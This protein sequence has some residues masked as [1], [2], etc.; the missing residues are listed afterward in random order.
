[1][2]G[3]WRNWRPSVCASC[4]RCERHLAVRVRKEA[5]VPRGHGVPTIRSTDR[6]RHVVRSAPF[7]VRWARSA[8]AV[9]CSS[10]GLRLRTIARTTRKRPQKNQKKAHQRCALNH[11]HVPATRRTRGFCRT[12]VSSHDLRYGLPGFSLTPQ[13]LCPVLPHQGGAPHWCRQ[14]SIITQLWQ[15]KNSFL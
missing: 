6:P 4:M 11:G 13:D 9:T 14:R 3:R 7:H 15:Q 12:C 5:Y 1:M 10:F 2:Q 8:H